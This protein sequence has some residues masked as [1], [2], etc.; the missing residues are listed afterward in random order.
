VIEEEE[1]VRVVRSEEVFRP[2]VIA[3]GR[4]NVAGLLAQAR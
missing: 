3:G 2:E 4:S 1:E